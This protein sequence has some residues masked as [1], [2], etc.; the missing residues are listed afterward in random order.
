KSAHKEGRKA[1]VA[2]GGPARADRAEPL[3]EQSDALGERAE[4]GAPV[5]VQL[6]G[7][8]KAGRR[9]LGPPLEQILTRQP[10]ARRVQ[11]DRREALGVVLQEVLGLG[12]RGVETG[13]PGGIGPAGSA[14]I[15]PR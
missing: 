3:A 7:E 15:Q 9:L 10:V 11:L 1:L 8:A 13:L 6:G 2:G 12:A 5:C 4:V 14:D